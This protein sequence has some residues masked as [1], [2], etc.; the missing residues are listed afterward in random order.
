[1]KLSFHILMVICHHQSCSIINVF[2]AFSEVNNIDAELH[3]NVIMKWNFPCKLDPNITGVLVIQS[4]PRPSRDVI[5]L[6][7]GVP[8]VFHPY[9][10]RVQLLTQGFPDGVVALKMNSVRIPDAGKYQCLIQTPNSTD[11]RFFYIKLRG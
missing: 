5:L 8:E 3:A 2:S 10:G 4:H 11:Y 6:R 7:G 9:E 1:M